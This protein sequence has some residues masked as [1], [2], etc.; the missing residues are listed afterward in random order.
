MPESLTAIIVVSISS[1]I[2]VIVSILSIL[3]DRKKHYSN[4]IAQHRMEWI[5]KLYELGAKLI[6]SLSCLSEN[7]DDDKKN[8]IEFL[9]ASILL[10]LKPSEN[11]YDEEK[12]LI[13]LLKKDNSEIKKSINE[14]RCSL[15]IICD[16]Q[17]TKVKAEAGRR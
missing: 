4:V 7:I 10:R 15:Q 12:E 3:F 17:W 2:T 9:K 5:N 16:K 11:A 8:E 13:V 1:S 14:L 6:A